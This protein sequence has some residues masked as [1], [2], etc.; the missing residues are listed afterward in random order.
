MEAYPRCVLDHVADMELRGHTE[1]TIYAR[2]R[3]LHRMRLALPVP[4]LEATADQLMAW[5]A[6]LTVGPDATVAYVSHARS[7]YGWAVS[8]G[9][10]EH[11][12]ALALPVP[13]VGRRLPR[14]IPEANLMRAIAGAPDRIRPWL[15]LAAWCGLRAKEIAYL[16]RENVMETA[17]PP[18]LLV[19]ADA[20]KGRR[21]R[22]VPL[23]AFALAELERHGLPGRGWIFRRGDDLP[24][25]NKPWIISNLANGYLHE[26]GIPE[27]IHQLRH[28][29]GTET[30]RATRDLRAV[31][32]LLGH[33]SPN[34]TA[35]YAAYS[36]ETAIAAVHALAV[37]GQVSRPAQIGA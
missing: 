34:A 16:R 6:N 29:F 23:C 19:A 8:A 17:D 5:R 13:K 31:Q 4:L 37:P 2:R 18:L 35:G 7:F 11:N 28:R 22:T 20:T 30:Y 36:R 15:V 24:G 26:S 32:E 1:G 25:P 21:E 27:S 14:P 3:A 12:P 9:L 10:L 33:A